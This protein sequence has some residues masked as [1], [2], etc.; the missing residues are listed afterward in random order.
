MDNQGEDQQPSDQ[1]RF[2]IE[3]LLVGQNEKSE[4]EQGFQEKSEFLN[5]KMAILKNTLS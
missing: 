4:M 5:S 1:K 2:Y 3:S